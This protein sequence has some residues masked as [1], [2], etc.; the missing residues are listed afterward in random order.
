M[1][2]YGLGTATGDLGGVR[3]WGHA[4]WHYGFK[5]GMLYLPDVGASVVALCNENGKTV[6]I[7]AYLLA[8]AVTELAQGDDASLQGSGVTPT[9]RED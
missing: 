6:E 4:G 3:W 8:Q 7:A 1:E 9:P 2:G 5:S